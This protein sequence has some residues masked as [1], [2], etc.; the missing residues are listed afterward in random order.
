MTSNAKHVEQVLMPETMSSKPRGPKPTGKEEVVRAILNSS[1]RLFAQR[2][3]AGV[4]LRDISTD[5]NVNVGLIHRHV[6]NRD[7]LIRDTLFHQA[8]STLKRVAASYD[9]NRGATA[10]L[11]HLSDEPFIRLIAHAV[12]EGLE[13]ARILP[14][15]P[16]IEFAIQQLTL[17]QTSGDVDPD[18]DVHLMVA[19]ATAW[20]MG[21]I[22]FEPFILRAVRLA[23]DDEPDLKALRASVSKLMLRMF[24]KG[25]AH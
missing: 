19:S 20:M 2:G 13:P 24:N 6:G 17:L 10:Y 4:S 7:A 8:T 9:P 11:E 14:S 22:L 21:W 18:T 5:A 16:M 23:D 12:V 25:G 3:F 1:A 15:F